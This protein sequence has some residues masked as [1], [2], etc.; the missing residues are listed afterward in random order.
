MKM[1]IPQSVSLNDS[2]AS[3]SILDHVEKMTN[4]GVTPSSSSST[5]EELNG[6]KRSKRARIVKYFEGNFVVYNIEDEPV[7]FKDVMDSSKVK[8]W[9]EAVKSKM[10]SIVSNGTWMLVYLPLE[11]IAIGFQWIFN[12]KMKPDETVDKFKASLKLR[13]IKQKEGTYYFDTYSLVAQLTTIHV[14]I[15]HTLVY[16][17]SIC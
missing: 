14:L 15:A 8:Q 7:T 1:G 6:P 12:N 3:T 17:L 2:L 11:C 10:D 4:G 16:N 13:D 5:H 9:K